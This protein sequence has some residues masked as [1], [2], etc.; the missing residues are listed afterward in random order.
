MIHE[1]ERIRKEVFVAES[2]SAVLIL[3]W[4]GLSKP[5]KSSFRTISI[6]VEI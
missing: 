4:R 6:E 3:A 5:Q 1:L 2:K